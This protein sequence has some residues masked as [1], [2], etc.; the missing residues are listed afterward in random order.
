MFQMDISWGWIRTFLVLLSWRKWCVEYCSRS[1]LLSWYY[2]EIEMHVGFA[3]RW[4]PRKSVPDQLPN[5]HWIQNKVEWPDLVLCL[6]LAVEIGKQSP[7]TSPLEKNGSLLS[8]DVASPQKCA[9][10]VVSQQTTHENKRFFEC[11]IYKVNRKSQIP[12]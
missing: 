7:W 8:E 6:R 4:V 10:V 3:V 2:V 12:M 9:P 5:L 11:R 1:C